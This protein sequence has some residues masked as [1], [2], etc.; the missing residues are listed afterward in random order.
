MGEAPRYVFHPLERRGVLLGL[1]A[2]QLAA[3]AT[4]LMLAVVVHASVAGAPGMA[5]AVVV[6]AGFT[7]GSL[8]RRHQR[9][10]GEWALEFAGWAARRRHSPAIDDLPATGPAR[11]RTNAP[12]GVALITDA[13]APG[14]PA[15]AVVADRRERTVAGVI[16]VHGS[17][18]SLLDPDDQAAELE[19]WRRVLG[20]LSRPGSP[21]VR[22]QWLHRSAGFGAPLECSAPAPA[23][24]GDDLR[25]VAGDSYRRLVA[26]TVPAMNTHRS[27]VVLVVGGRAGGG[28][29]V[30]ALR[31]ELRLLDGQLRAAGLSPGPPLGSDELS[32]M[33]AAPSRTGGA[34][35]RPGPAWPLA[36][37][38]RWSMVRADGAWHAT[39]W[40]AEWPR[41]PV[42]P[43][44]LAP[45]LVGIKRASMSVLMS[46]VAPDR[47]A[48]EAR[49]ARTSDLADAQLRAR[50][51]FLTS[52]RRERESEGARHRE[53][54]LADGH[55]EF[56]FSAY[57]TVSA[58]DRDGLVTACAE[59][60]H[61]AQSA[62]V[63]LRR[64]FGR[65]AE[66]YGW[67][68]PLGRG[69]R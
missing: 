11:V 19:G 56:R 64:L 60:E 38:D 43:D 5:L 48:R 53:E 31:R 8:W 25:R 28:E 68:Q 17:S 40:V 9:P 34:P 35:G 22:V 7:F 4:G 39:Y 3:A 42:G 23:A 69:L 13:S 44:F 50:A 45:L 14:S 2:G 61:A 16:P 12:A 6:A 51:G 63:E 20:A 21:V 65:Q 55:S 18:L 67:T 47:A 10:V 46:P 37:D 49:S 29:S 54:E 36:V 33:I 41:V 52:A 59:A 66:A 24:P 27:W 32:R 1:G 57:L 62:R 15:I 58:D 26:D 30:R